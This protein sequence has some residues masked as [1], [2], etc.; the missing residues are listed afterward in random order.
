MSSRRQSRSI[1]YRANLDHMRETLSFLVRDC[2]AGR[3]ELCEPLLRELQ[4]PAADCSREAG[5]NLCNGE[6][7][8]ELDQLPNIDPEYLHPIDV[9]ALVGPDQPRHP[10]A[11]WCCTARCANV[12]TRACSPRKPHA[13]CAGSVARCAPSIPP[14]CRC[15]TIP[16]PSTPRCRSCATWPSGARACCGSA[17]NVTAP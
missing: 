15:P 5:E 17:P 4:H 11:F 3:A 6:D 14:A 9:D 7:A 10:R 1:I 2:C 8:H 12:P 16:T 13:C